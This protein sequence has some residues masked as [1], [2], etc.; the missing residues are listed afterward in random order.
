MTTHH[1]RG[2]LWC[3]DT[4][5]RRQRRRVFCYRWFCRRAFYFIFIFLCKRQQDNKEMDRAARRQIMEMSYE[6]EAKGREEKCW[7]TQ[8]RARKVRWCV[9]VK[10]PCLPSFF[11]L[12]Y[13]SIALMLQFMPDSTSGSR[14]LGITFT[15][16]V[17]CAYLSRLCKQRARRLRSLGGRR[18]R[19]RVNLTNRK[20]RKDPE[21]KNIHRHTERERKRGGGVSVCVKRETKNEWRRRGWWWWVMICCV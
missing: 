5:R 7:C 2:I 3:I 20:E 16:C 9:G 1:W 15:V 14:Q 4:A 10:Q 21:K 13:V 6:E 11:I 12:C 8:E 17:P 19:T 18:R